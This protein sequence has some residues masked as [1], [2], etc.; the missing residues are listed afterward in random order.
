MER[1][2]DTL[3]DAAADSP[4]SVVDKLRAAFDRAMREGG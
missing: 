4:E 2:V 1:A 3:L